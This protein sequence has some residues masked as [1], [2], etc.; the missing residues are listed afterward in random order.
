MRDKGKKGPGDQ[1]F[2][3]VP[4]EFKAA[5]FLEWRTARK[6]S[7]DAVAKALAS[8]CPKLFGTYTGRTVAGW[9]KL[10][11]A[12]KPNADVPLALGMIYNVDHVVEF[13]GAVE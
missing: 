4:L 2:Q 8:W 9:E 6:L 1:P 7:Q 10:V 5:R 13:F 3:E 12:H 11:D